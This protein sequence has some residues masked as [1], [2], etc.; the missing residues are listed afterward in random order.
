ML[1]DVS[2]CVQFFAS[3]TADTCTGAKNNFKV[4]KATASILHYVIPPFK[5]SAHSPRVIL[6]FMCWMCMKPWNDQSTST[7]QKVESFLVVYDTFEDKTRKTLIDNVSCSNPNSTTKLNK[8][9]HGTTGQRIR[10]WTGALNSFFSRQTLE[11]RNN[12]SDNI[13]HQF[14]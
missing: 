7:R 1:Q 10:L 13:F 8:L 9:H 12:H 11:G 5:T 14:T 2:F 6:T 4:F 3:F